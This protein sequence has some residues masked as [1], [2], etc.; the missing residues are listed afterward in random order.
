MPLKKIP[1]LY[2]IAFLTISLMLL[3]LV[4]PAEVFRAS[5]RGVSIWWDVLFPAL[6][7]FFVISELMLGVGIVH[8][9]GTLLDPLMR[10]VF[11]IPGIGGFVV[12]MGFAAGYPVGAKLTAQLWEQKLIN[13]EEGERLVSF[14]TS[15]DP[16]FLI[17]AVSV[18]FFHDASLAGI[19]AAAHYGTAMLLGLLMRYH[20][21]DRPATAPVSTAADNAKKRSRSIWIRAF[22]TMHDARMKDGR[23]VG[24][25]LRIAVASS[26][27]LTLVVGGLVVFFSAVMEVLTSAHIMNIFYIG[28]NAVLQLF[29]V[30]LP[31]SQAVANGFFEVTLG[32]KAAGGAG[33]HISLVYKVAI[34]AFILSWAGLSVHAQVVS[35][36]HRTNLR[37]TPFC[38]ARLLHSFMAFTA[39]LVLWEPMQ[40]YRGA[41]AAF[42]PVMDDRSPLTTLWRLTLPWG[43]AVFGAVIVTLILLF[44]LH[45]LVK[46]CMKRFG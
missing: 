15:S 25:M 43:I 12:A 24:E 41:V 9:F 13:R 18:G 10:P 22:E 39:V 6:F 45:F 8:F 11:R 1:S 32:A 17:G 38:A 4:Y 44:V 19:L 3:M 27:Q 37:Y 33:T 21:R 46:Q 28:I 34:A 14:T 36:L 23:P 40:S 5:L 29:D 16:I 20:G 35:L 26:L 2:F 7:P 42:I 30:P 31:L